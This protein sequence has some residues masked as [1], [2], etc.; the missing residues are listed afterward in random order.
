[1]KLLKRSELSAKKAPV[2]GFPWLSHVIE[3]NYSTF[4]Q[5]LQPAI[6]F[7][8][9]FFPLSLFLT[10]LYLHLLSITLPSPLSLTIFCHI[11]FF[12]S[13]SHHLRFQIFK[14]PQKVYVTYNQVRCFKPGFNNYAYHS[15]VAAWRIS[16]AGSDAVA[17]RIFP[18]AI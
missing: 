12:H 3:V 6:F 17:L 4:F 1:M 16:I 9:S 18:V 5:C 15:L 11:L 14:M 7:F 2:V 8:F 13:I 10:L